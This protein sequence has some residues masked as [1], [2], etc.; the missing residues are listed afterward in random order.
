MIYRTDYTI[1]IIL[2]LW[3][4]RYFCK[5]HGVIFYAFL[6][7]RNRRVWVL[8]LEAMPQQFLQ[9]IPFSRCLPSDSPP[10]APE[11]LLHKLQWALSQLLLSLLTYGNHSFGHCSNTKLLLLTEQICW[12]MIPSTGTV[13]VV[14]YAGLLFDKWKLCKQYSNSI[15]PHDDSVCSIPPAYHAQN[16]QL[17]SHDKYQG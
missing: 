7:L 2:I 4:S 8:L 6:L 12:W 5:S 15:L 17:L 16:S 14:I 3:H 10:Q 13:M 11:N 1:S 9:S